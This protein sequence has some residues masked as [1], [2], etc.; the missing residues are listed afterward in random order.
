MI[1]FVFQYALQSDRDFEK[2]LREDRKAMEEEKADKKER[3]KERERQK[4]KEREAKLAGKK[5]MWQ[6]DKKEGEQGSGDEVS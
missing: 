6:D 3:A 5:G 4:R 1:V 2:M